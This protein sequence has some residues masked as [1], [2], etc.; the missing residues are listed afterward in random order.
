MSDESEIAGQY[1]EKVTQTEREAR[2]RRAVAKKAEPLLRGLPQTGTHYFSPIDFRALV[3]FLLE[4]E[5]S[6]IARAM[7]S[8]RFKIMGLEFV[9][10]H[11]EGETSTLSAFARKHG[12]P[13]QTLHDRAGKAF[14]KMKIRCGQKLFYVE[15]LMTILPARSG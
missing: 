3:Q 6:K 11:K 9:C 13:Q 10:R 4:G 7:R 15:D 2:H 1:V 5:P 8:D 14:L 12:V